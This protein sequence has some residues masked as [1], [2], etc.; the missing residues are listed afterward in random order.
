MNGNYPSQKVDGKKYD[1]STKILQEIKPDSSAK[2]IWQLSY[3]C[4]RV[5]GALG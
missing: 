5:F 3:T 2:P 1:W 4:F